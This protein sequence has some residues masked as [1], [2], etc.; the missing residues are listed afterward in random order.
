M[1]EIEDL[2]DLIRRVSTQ[3]P[4]DVLSALRDASLREEEGSPAEIVMRTILENVSLAGERGI[5]ICQDTGVPTFWV[6]HHPS[7]RRADL[8]RLIEEAVVR[9][10]DMGL[11]R[12]NAVHPITGENS[13]N[14]IGICFPIVK[15]KEWDRSGMRIS[16]LLKGGGSENVSAQYSLPDPT[17]GAGR[18]LEGIS[19]VVL[20]TVWKAQGLGCP[21]AIIGVGIGGD[22]ATSWEVA[23]RQI[24]RKIWD[25]NPDPEIARLEE[26]LMKRINELGIG[27][28][29]LGGKTTAL[30]VKIGIAH[31]IPAT[32]F[33]SVSYMCWAC[34]RGELELKNP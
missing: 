5:P 20:Y 31:R 28:M 17:L 16:L 13:G 29:G 26:D 4:P 32:F 22:R 33:V 21:P 15:M 14:N 7:I 23:K 25:R 19:K 34:R 24:L 12:P 30:S 2:I 18:D 6:E 1:L 27:P 3:L 8:I 9:S 10:T 11:L